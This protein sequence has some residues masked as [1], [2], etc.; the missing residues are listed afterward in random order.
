[1]EDYAEI[2]ETR[3][4][5]ILED[6]NK[7]LEKFDLLLTLGKE[8]VIKI[9]RELVNTKVGGARN[10]KKIINKVYFKL[11]KFKNENLAKLEEEYSKLEGEESSESEA[12]ETEAE[13]SLETELAEPKKIILD[14][15]EELRDFLI[16]EN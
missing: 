14:Y 16:I 10:C 1:M 3:L 15:S 11:A 12:S 9:A 6:Y 13:E 7:Q 4:N 2:V 5:L 8:T